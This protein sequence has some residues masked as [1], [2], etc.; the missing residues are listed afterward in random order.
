MADYEVRC[1]YNLNKDPQLDDPEW[2]EIWSYEG[3]KLGHKAVKL[4]R[5]WYIIILPYFHYEKVVNEFPTI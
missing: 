4:F 5:K 2:S 1:N 3:S